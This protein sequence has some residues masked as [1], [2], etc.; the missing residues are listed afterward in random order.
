MSSRHLLQPKTVNMSPTLQ[1]PISSLTSTGL[2]ATKR[3]A[4]ASAAA[5]DPYLTTSKAAA[6]AT[7][8]AAAGGAAR[9]GS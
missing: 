5:A 2:S 4:L 6:H 1:V 3:A 7:A 9:R 8:L